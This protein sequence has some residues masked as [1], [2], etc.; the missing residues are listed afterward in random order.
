MARPR[1]RA[2]KG[3]HAGYIPSDLSAEKKFRER[4]LALRATGLTQKETAESFGVSVPT[5]ARWEAQ[6]RATGSLTPRR[7]L[8]GRKR[9]LSAQD[10]RRLRKWLVEDATLTDQQ[11]AVRLGGTVT[12]RVVN[13]YVTELGFT[14]KAPAKGDEPL[15]DHVVQETRQYLRCLKGVPMKRRCYMDETAI[16]ANEYPRRLRALAGARA[17]VPLPALSRRYTLYWAITSGGQLHSPVLRKEN[18]DDPNFLRYVR[19]TLAPH[20]TPGLTVIW[21]RLGRSGRSRNPVRIHYNPD[22]ARKI[23]GRGCNLLFLPPKGKYLNPIEEANNALKTGVRNAYNTSAA[24]VQSRQRTFDELQAEAIEVASRFTP[25][26]FKGWFQ[27]RGTMAAF[28]EAYPNN[29][30]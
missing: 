25:R 1:T 21:D 16:Y 18:C 20:L 24:R 26:H 3:R 7:S 22:A 28:N 11:L 19:D 5:I 8:S 10:V 4:V 9:K 29:E 23:R 15:T 14:P 13:G 27:H 30:V 17:H 2:G 12:G 6:R